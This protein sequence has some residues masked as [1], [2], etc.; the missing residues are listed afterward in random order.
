VDVFAAAPD[1]S[2]LVRGD[3]QHVRLLDAR[4]G[5]ARGDL[6][7]DVTG[8]TCLAVSPDGK[9]I[10]AGTR[11]GDVVLWDIQPAA[12]HA[13]TSRPGTTVAGLAFAPEGDTLAVALLP[14]A[15]GTR[16]EG[17]SLVLIDTAG[18]EKLVLP[19]LPGHTGGTRCVAYSPEGR[20]VASGG[21]DGTV[22]L[23]EAASGRERVCLEW[24]LD[25]VC[26]IAFA[27]DGLTLAS[28]SFDG[29]AKVWPR[30]VL[31]PLERQREPSTLVT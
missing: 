7:G 6:P 25:S 18:L 27:P 9:R 19:P 24:H 12:L 13:Q 14:A 20:F 23:W 22:R 4:T 11:T 21:E 26:A 10:A 3:R 28:G 8:L 17:G 29:T 30:E 2:V 16:V 5:V 31:R 15:S 1:G